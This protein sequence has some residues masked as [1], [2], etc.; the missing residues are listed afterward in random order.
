MSEIAGDSYKNEVLINGDTAIIKY[1][2]SGGMAQYGQSYQNTVTFSAGEARLRLTGGEAS[3]GTNPVYE[4]VV[5][6]SGTAKAGEVIGGWHNDRGTA[7]LN[8]V[9]VNGAT[10]GSQ[11]VGGYSN[12]EDAI[13]NEVIIHNVTLDDNW[14]GMDAK[15]VYGGV[16][17]GSG[18]ARDNKVTIYNG[19]IKGSVYGGSSISGVASGNRVSIAGGQFHGVI[20]GGNSFRAAASANHVDI[21]GGTF[22]QNIYGGYSATADASFNVVTLS[23]TTAFADTITGGITTGANGIA[24]FNT[25]YFNDGARISGPSGGV[26]RGGSSSSGQAL[27]NRIFMTLGTVDELQGGVGRVADHN[28]VEMSGGTARMAIGAHG[29]MVSNA[30]QVVI[31]GGTVTASVYGGWTATGSSPNN[32]VTIS[33]GTLSWVTGGRSDGNGNASNNE[34]YISGGE[35]VNGA[36]ITGGIATG[37]QGVRGNA[38]YNTV[39]LSGRPDL[40]L[41]RLYGGT[42]GSNDAF[43]GNTLNL[44]GF[45]G[46]V[47]SAANFEN[48]NFFLPAGIQNGDTMLAIFGTG[49]VDLTGTNIAITGV[50]TGSPLFVGDMVYLIDKTANTI[51]GFSGYSVNQGVML[52][53]AFEHAA[54]I[55]DALAVRITSAGANPQVKAFSEGRLASMAFVNQGAD[56]IANQAISRAVQ[57]TQNGPNLT[58]FAIMG[59]G[60]SRYQ[61]GSHID[62]EGV[63]AL[64]GLAWGQDLGVGRLTLGGFFEAGWGNIIPIT[65]SIAR[66]RL[67]ATVIPNTMAAVFW[68]GLTLPV[69]RWA[70]FTPRLRR[71]S[72]PSATISVA[73][74]WAWAVKKLVTTAIRCI[75]ACTAAWAMFSI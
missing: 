19:S 53:Y 15:T 12:L 57:D 47:I 1:N 72:A 32:V 4:N 63:S 34:I 29:S 11:I 62:V 27:N 71:V 16:S 50:E 30:N 9:E 33:G 36:N 40:T 13:G 46:A 26:V 67:K 3:F 31:K 56:F 41:A 18:V 21:S 5:N 64:A 14:G 24:E 73:E 35:F 44:K 38:T 75:T 45:S 37:N 22:S 69:H 7:Y 43:T 52:Q 65:A 10:V 74:I 60:K 70:V 39:T 8:K 25:V 61:S 68:A 28:Y 54:D 55:T 59:G 51:A 2:V 20:Y 42:A 48:Y 58:L 17:F 23:G 6:I 49:S 66:L